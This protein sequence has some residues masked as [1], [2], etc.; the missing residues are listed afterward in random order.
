[1]KFKDSS[2]MPEIER[3]YVTISPT[4]FGQ[5]QEPCLLDNPVFRE[6][7]WTIWLAVTIGFWC[8]SFTVLLMAILT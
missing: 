2:E 1:M 5:R 3:D 7:M 8:L 4:P 6:W